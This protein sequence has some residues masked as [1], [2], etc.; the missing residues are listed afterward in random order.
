MLKKY[1]ESKGLSQYQLAIELKW[2]LQTYCDREAN[3]PGRQIEWLVDFKEH[4]GKSWEEIGA[5]IE[6]ELR[7]K[8]KRKP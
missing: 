4:S 2:R 7:E 5:E 6:R 1:R 3:F 8:R